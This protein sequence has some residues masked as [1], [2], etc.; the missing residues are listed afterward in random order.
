MGV[1]AAE[2]SL[3]QEQACDDEKIP[4][5]GPLP[6]GQA[7]I[8][9]FAKSKLTGSPRLLVR[10]AEGPESSECEERRSNA[11]KQRD[12]RERRP[13]DRIRCQRVAD[14]RRGRPVV[15]V[16][17]GFARAVR[18]CN[19]RGPGEVRNPRRHLFGSNA[20]T[21]QSV[22]LSGRSE[23]V[24]VVIFKLVPRSGLGRSIGK[25][26]LGCIPAVGL[27]VFE[28]ARSGV[29]RAMGRVIELHR[30]ARARYNRP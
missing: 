25:D 16:G 3:E 29:C 11:K 18:G 27:G 10:P 22:L 19:P 7:H 26:I 17:V 14:Q 13:E 4:D 23:P 24:P 1:R 6:R 2:E 28:D 8:F 15:R 21:P 30:R 20:G 5:S 9:R 12:E